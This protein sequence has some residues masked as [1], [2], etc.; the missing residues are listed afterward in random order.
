[1]LYDLRDI[2]YNINKKYKN[3]I[4]YIN[5]KERNKIIYYFD[6]NILFWFSLQRYFT[7][8][9]RR[10]NESENGSSS[11]FLFTFFSS[12]WQKTNTSA[13]IRCART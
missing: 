12:S 1:M 10:Y 5:K 11:A 9:Q 6:T 8:V 4:A 2:L 3:F 13:S 7:H